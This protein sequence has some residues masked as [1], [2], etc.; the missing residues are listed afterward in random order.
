M[1]FLSTLGGWDNT[2]QFSFLLSATLTTAVYLFL[3]L[4]RARQNLPTL[5]FSLFIAIGAGL[6]LL[7][8]QL[9]LLLFVAF[10]LLLLSS[11]TLLRLTSKSERVLEAA[12]EMFLWTLV[13][14]AALFFTFT[15]L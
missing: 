5:L 15:L 10:E 13:G 1:Y 6:L 4:T 8:T 3:T 14:S 9:L 2:L 7:F 11:L 12:L